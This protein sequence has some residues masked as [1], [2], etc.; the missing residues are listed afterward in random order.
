MGA[1]SSNQLSDIPNIPTNTFAFRGLKFKSGEMIGL[2]LY[3]LF[4]FCQVCGTR[5]WT[6]EQLEELSSPDLSKEVFSS[7]YPND[8]YCNSAI[9]NNPACERQLYSVTGGYNTLQL[10]NSFVF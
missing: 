5:R 1:T 3:K 10:A 7:N 6:A 8:A 4:V 2:P 9:C